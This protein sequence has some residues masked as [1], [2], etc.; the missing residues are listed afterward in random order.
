MDS[1]IFTESGRFTLLLASSPYDNPSFHFHLKEA[2]QYCA[3][4]RV[5]AKV[6]IS[7]ELGHELRNNILDQNRYALC[8]LTHAQILQFKM[9]HLLLAIQI[10]D[11]YRRLRCSISRT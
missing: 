2:S 7:L 3:L 6:V 5:Q 11:G 4:G 1:L 8:I 10:D 9:L